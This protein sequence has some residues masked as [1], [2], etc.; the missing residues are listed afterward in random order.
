[1]STGHSLQSSVHLYV[2]PAYVLFGV[3]GCGACLSWGS[4]EILEFYPFMGGPSVHGRLL[5]GPDRGSHA[6]YGLFIR[7]M[8]SLW[9]VEF[10][11]PLWDGS[12]MSTRHIPK[13]FCSFIFDVAARCFAVPA[14]AEVLLRSLKPTFSILPLCCLREARIRY[15]RQRFLLVFSQQFKLTIVVH[16]ILW[17][18]L[19]VCPDDFS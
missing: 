9:Q 11:F 1:M 18:F 17:F 16:A 5:L 6:D 8:V 7:Y 13:A 19:M 15:Y 2:L 3:V 14:S 4:S 10:A 12:M